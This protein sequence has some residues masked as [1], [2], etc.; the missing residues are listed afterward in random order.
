MAYPVDVTYEVE[1]TPKGLKNL[2]T[3]YEYT[4]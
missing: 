1:V 4:Q 3:L 2:A